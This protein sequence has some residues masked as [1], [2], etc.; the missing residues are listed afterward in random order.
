ML[1]YYLVVRA[2]LLANTAAQG[3]SLSGDAHFLPAV[4]ITADSGTALKA[5]VANNTNTTASIAG[6]AVVIDKTLGDITA[7][8]SSR[9]PVSSVDVIKPDIG[10]PGV[11]ILAA[12]HTVESS[13]E[14]EYGFLSGTSMSSPHNAGAGALVAGATGWNYQ[15]QSAIMMTAKPTS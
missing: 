15:V 8:F 5:W 4:H 2:V 9:G 11:D 1:T 13:T 10:G 14:P 7:S 3:N 6:Q 12:V